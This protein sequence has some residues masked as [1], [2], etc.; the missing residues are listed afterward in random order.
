M[1]LG[2]RFDVRWT[3]KKYLPKRVTDL[4]RSLLPE[5]IFYPGYGQTM[6]SGKKL[7][8]LLRLLNECLSK[9]LEGDLIECGVF[10]G[11]SLVQIGRMAL[12]MAPSKKVFGADTFEGHPFDHP[13]DIPADN[14]LVHR[15]GLFSG[16]DY[17]L[18]SNILRRNRL[19][20]TVLLKGMLRDTLPIVGDRTFCF[21]HLDVDL[22]TSTKQAL[23]FV[24]PR[25]VSGGVI[26]FD[27]YGG[28]DTPGVE[29]AVSE[30]LPHVQIR[31]TI[32]SSIEGQAFWIKP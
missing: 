23:E 17:N 29:K 9:K 14:Q 25:L 20:N 16:T 2:K 27:D 28:F 8:E 30:L 18:V 3:A 32:I 21:A 31:H 11:G 6:L 10:R 4:L 22:Y 24:E 1:D 12:K 26:I 5:S 13:E 7:D 19:D 15:K